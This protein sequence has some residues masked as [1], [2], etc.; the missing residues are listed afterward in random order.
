MT[1]HAVGL[2]T[3]ATSTGLSRRLYQQSPFFL[4]ARFSVLSGRRGVWRWFAF[5]HATSPAACRTG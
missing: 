4:H 3:G 2:Q 1:P 5:A